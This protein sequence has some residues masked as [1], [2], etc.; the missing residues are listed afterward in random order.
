MNDR[1]AVLIQDEVVFHS[2]TGSSTASF[3]VMLGTVWRMYTKAQISLLSPSGTTDMPRRAILTQSRAD[4]DCPE[5]VQIRAE[6]LSPPGA[7]FDVESATPSPDAVN[8]ANAAV[9]KS[10]H[11]NKQSSLADAKKCAGVTENANEGYSCLMIKFAIPV[12]AS[13]DVVGCTKVAIAV[14]FT[15]NTDDVGIAPELVPLND[16]DGKR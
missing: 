1:N 9:G 15:A 16:W 4:G 2:A 8:A 11:A 12:Q 5:V 10:K 3:N 13:I 7:Y 6:I 14:K